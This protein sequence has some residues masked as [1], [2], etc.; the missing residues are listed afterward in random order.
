MLAAAVQLPQ[1]RCRYLACSYTQMC[2]ALLARIG[3]QRA[4]HPV[5]DSD[6]AAAVANQ[7]L[8]PRRQWRR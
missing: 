2:A 4:V 3:V 6:A 1:Q 5:T 8:L 7:P